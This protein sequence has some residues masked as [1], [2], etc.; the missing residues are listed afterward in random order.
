MNPMTSLS[1]TPSLTGE[2]KIESLNSI[3]NRVALLKSK[4][5]SRKLIRANNDQSISFNT[6]N[7]EGVINNQQT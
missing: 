3:Y 6:N 2:A 7:F 1:N 5:I 4:N